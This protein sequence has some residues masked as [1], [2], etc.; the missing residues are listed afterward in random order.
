MSWVVRLGGRLFALVGFMVPVGG[1]LVWRD[2]VG[3]GS[4]VLRL[5][6][7]EFRCWEFQ[8]LQFLQGARPE[9]LA[10]RSDSFAGCFMIWPIGLFTNF[11]A[12]FGP[13]N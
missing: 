3:R 4:V 7:S 10:N 1:G 6:G 11:T 2:I 5:M 8:I 13:A 9:L 12:V